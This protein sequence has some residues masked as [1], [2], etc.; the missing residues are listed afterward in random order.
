MS[1]SE[2]ELLESSFEGLANDDDD[3]EGMGADIPLVVPLE[4]SSDDEDG[5]G[6]QSDDNDSDGWTEEVTAHDKWVLNEC[7]GISDD[8]LE[9]CKEP[10]HHLF[11]NDDVLNLIVQETNKYAQAKDPRNWEDT[12]KA[13]IRKFVG[14]CLQMGNV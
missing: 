5:D 2:L 1:D 12:D 9:N 3:Y 6:D 8:V 10:F 13:E 4:D 7:S 14:F 11:S